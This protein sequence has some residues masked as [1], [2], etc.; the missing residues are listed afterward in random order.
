MN[1]G[2]DLRVFDVEHRREGTISTISQLNKAVSRPVKGSNNWWR[3]VR[4]L[5]YSKALL[6]TPFQLDRIFN[7][8]ITVLILVLRTYIVVRILSKTC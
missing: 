3:A 6:F 2:A 1:V 4:A 8:V 5:V 7:S